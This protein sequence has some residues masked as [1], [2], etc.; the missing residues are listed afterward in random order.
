[1][2]RASCPAGRCSVGRGNTQPFHKN[3][4]LASTS[5]LNS[6]DLLTGFQVS[7]VFVAFVR[8]SVLTGAT[9]NAGYT[10]ICKEI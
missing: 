10:E 5:Y 6:A 9:K 2:L 1:M 4:A 7:C 3:S 8:P